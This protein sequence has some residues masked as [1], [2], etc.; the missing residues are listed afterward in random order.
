MSTQ[1]RRNLAK[2]RTARIDRRGSSIKAAASEWTIERFEIRRAEKRK[3]K[4]DRR[5]RKTDETSEN[6]STETFAGN[7]EKRKTAERKQDRVRIECEENPD[8]FGRNEEQIGN[9]E[10]ELGQRNE[11]EGGE[12]REANGTIRIEFQIER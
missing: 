9:R 10:N 11:I 5:K 6:V 12:S 1:N 8:R 2:Q 7:C 4:T 3:P